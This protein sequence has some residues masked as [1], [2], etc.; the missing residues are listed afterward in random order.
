MRIIASMLAALALTTAHARDTNRYDRVETRGGIEFSQRGGLGSSNEVVTAFDRAAFWAAAESEP[1]F[2]NAVGAVA[3]KV[4]PSVI[5]GTNGDF[6]AYDG[7]AK[8]GG[9]DTSV[10]FRGDAAGSIDGD[11][12]SISRDLSVYV[13]GNLP[14]SPGADYSYTLKFPGSPDLALP[15]YVDYP[16]FNGWLFSADLP[17]GHP[18]RSGGYTRVCLYYPNDEFKWISYRAGAG[19]SDDYF[20]YRYD[21]HLVPGSDYSKDSA[22][23][24]ADVTV[25]G[26]ARRVTF[27]RDWAI[28]QV[29]VRDLKAS[30]SSEV[31]GAIGSGSADAEISA[32]VSRTGF[33]TGV[34]WND[35][36]VTGTNF[37]AKLLGRGVLV[38][39]VYFCQRD[40]HHSTSQ[41]VIRAEL[42]LYVRHADIG[43]SSICD[44]MIYKKVAGVN[45]WAWDSAL[46]SA[47]VTGPSSYEMSY[48]VNNG[49][50]KGNL[51][52]NGSQWGFTASVATWWIAR[53]YVSGQFMPLGGQKTLTNALKEMMSSGSS[54]VGY[55]STTRSNVQS[56]YEQSFFHIHSSDPGSGEF[57]SWT[58]QIPYDWYD[59][60][61]ETLVS[62]V[63]NDL[64]AAKVP[65]DYEE[66]ASK[67]RAA[68]PNTTTVAG[69]PLSSNVTLGTLTIQGQTYDGS[70]NKTINIDG[71][72]Y[73][74][75]TNTVN[76]TKS[77]FY[78]SGLGVEWTFVPMNGE[79]MFIATTNVN[80]E[81]IE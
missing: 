80:R 10:L 35:D 67:A 21:G 53:Q 1:G 38:A 44:N 50:T 8:R 28:P 12:A 17:E 18:L 66:I 37:V 36:L 33:G 78:D 77:R 60:Y 39:E 13:N 70:A 25:G 27:V 3:E 7:S 22:S 65:E 43:F 61:R 29:F 23:F 52:F 5:V 32:A 55:G 16:Y 47:N 15:L 41:G 68:V 46:S 34:M 69:K 49:G 58:E 40:V 79:Y 42:P 24:Q 72:D 81:V 63:T 56:V 30:P 74:A 62:S 64:S 45:E 19:V 20:L 73:E 31:S 76:E 4:D 57:V 14:V 48:A 11:G 75:M 2:S 71:M 54:N 6:I 51:K 26:S 9:A 59:N